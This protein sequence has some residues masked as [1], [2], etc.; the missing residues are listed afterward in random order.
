MLGCRCC[1]R[2]GRSEWARLRKD[3][4]VIVPRS[5]WLRLEL[6]THHG[7][8]PRVCILSQRCR[9]DWRATKPLVEDM[10]EAIG[11]SFI[12]AEQIRNNKYA[13]LK[14]QSLAAHSGF[15][16]NQKVCAALK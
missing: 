14:M 8:K 16:S 13:S 1:C 4:A 7:L 15:G 9:Y 6:M 12:S 11:A 10:L 3:S 5:V 2:R